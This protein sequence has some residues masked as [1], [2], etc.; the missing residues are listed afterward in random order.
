MRMKMRLKKDEEYEDATDYIESYFDNGEIDDA[1]D[2]DGEG[3]G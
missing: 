1:L 3:E 2:D